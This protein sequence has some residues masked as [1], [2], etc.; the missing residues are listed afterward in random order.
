MKTDLRTLSGNALIVGVAVVL[1]VFF[2]WAFFRGVIDLYPFTRANAGFLISLAIL[3]ACIHILLLALVGHRVILKPLV[4][5]VLLV[6]ATAAYFMDSYHVV[7]DDTMI[8]NM[9]LTDTGEALDLFSGKL[10]L[11][12]VLLGVLPSLLISR[13]RIEKRP[14]GA[15]LF[16]RLKLLAG[17]LVVAAASLYLFSSHYASFFREHKALRAYANPVYLVY[18]AGKYMKGR[19]KKALPFQS[20]G[21]DAHLGTGDGRKRLV[22]FVV[23]ETARF[24]RLSLNGYGRDT[25]PRLEKEG[26]I[27]FD[28]VW[29]CGTST[30]VSVPCMFSV[31]GRE[32]YD[33]ERVLAT[34]NVLDIL[35]RAGVA[36]LWRDNNSSSKGVAKRVPHEDFKTPDNN[37][38]CDI[39]CRDEGMLAGLQ[40][41]VDR[42]QDRNILIVL[43]QMG[44]HGPA[45]YKRYP[46]AF[47]RFKPV[48]GTNQLEKCSTQELDNA[49][50][51][52]ILYTDYF[53]SKVI[54][55]LKANAGRFE[56]GMLYVSDHGESLG[57][58]GLYLHGLPYLFSP[59]SQRHVPAL[60]W[61]AKGFDHVN[62]ARLRES[63]H[64]HYS[65]DNIFHTLLG[66]MGVQT[67]LYKKEMDMLAPAVDSR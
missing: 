44:N 10:L 1:V 39:E 3:L 16:S 24:D 14:L 40:A 52:A 20:I 27:S 62:A 67:R 51:N 63:R 43:H 25:T 13:V 57:E 47:E 54:G 64:H 12:V 41:Y 34:E 33:Q 4:I 42:H 48:C 59:E 19:M 32:A 65:H 66:L 28:N 37:P 21:G 58:N 49:Y 36:I 11:Y 23:G 9:L 18:S 26:V 50:D 56:T 38:V 35:Q 46:P 2:N 22:I 55:F 15:A 61:L 60:L 8:H 6:A 30:A 53:L 7:I 17:T 31:Y 29:S 5:V 45:Y